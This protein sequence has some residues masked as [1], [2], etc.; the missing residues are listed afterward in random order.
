[1][2]SDNE[3]VPDEF[4]KLLI[5]QQALKKA[6]VRYSQSFP[7]TKAFLNDLNKRNSKPNLQPVEERSRENSIIKDLSIKWE[8]LLW[9]I[10]L[11]ER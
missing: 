3:E 6:I 10:L 8:S 9:Q 1:M 2:D 4:I 7:E 11:F 5:A